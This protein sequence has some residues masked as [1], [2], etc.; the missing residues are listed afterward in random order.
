MLA[1]VGWL[2]RQG[3]STTVSSHNINLDFPQ[4][5]ASYS[6]GIHEI[7]GFLAIPLTHDG[8]DHIIFFRRSEAEEIR[9]AGNP[10]LA[11]QEGRRLEPRTSFKLWREFITGQA[12]PWT[13]AELEQSSQISFVYGEEL[14]RFIWPK[15][16][17]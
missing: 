7:A 6:P 8:V 9:W 12:R 17:S 10:Y 1:I 11:E 14:V 5:G 16:E 15:A 4:I 13:E 3:F 2:R